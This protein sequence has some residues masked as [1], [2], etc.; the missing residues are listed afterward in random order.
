M[1]ARSDTDPTTMLVLYVQVPRHYSRFCLITFTQTLADKIQGLK[2][3]IKGKITGNPDLVQHG[4][5][6]KSGEER[7]KKLTGEVLCLSLAFKTIDT[8]L[9]HICRT[10]SITPLLNL[11]QAKTSIPRRIRPPSL[12]IV[13]SRLLTPRL[14]TVT[15]VIKATQCDLLEALKTTTWI[16]Q[17]L[18]NLPIY[19]TQVLISTPIRLMP[20]D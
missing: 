10:M 3:E 13:H 14:P 5:E 18:L 7:R 12:P 4:R 8:D 11:P 1:L 6:V 19:P 20:L 9:S 15:R 17:T 2:Y 16:T